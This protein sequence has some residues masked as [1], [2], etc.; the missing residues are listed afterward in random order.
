MVLGFD[1]TGGKIVE[2][3]DLVRFIEDVS[4]R[5][6]DTLKGLLTFLAGSQSDTSPCTRA[7]ERLR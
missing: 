5:G 2:G 4:G 1:G 3:K 7:C 6:Y